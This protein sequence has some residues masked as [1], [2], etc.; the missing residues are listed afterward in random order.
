MGYIDQRLQISEMKGDLKDLFKVE[1]KM[2]GGG[3]NT[4]DNGTTSTRQV[5]KSDCRL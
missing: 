5:S 1:I 3:S 4:M 2:G